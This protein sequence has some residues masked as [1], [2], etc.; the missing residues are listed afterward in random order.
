MEV[1][2]CGVK[3]DVGCEAEAASAE[4]EGAGDS[5]LGVVLV[6]G[7]GLREAPARGVVERRGV[8]GWESAEVEGGGEGEGGLVTVSG[9]GSIDVERNLDAG[10]WTRV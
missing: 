10:R 5:V 8:G 1:D 2:G 3:A 6:C 4:G 9:W 7:E